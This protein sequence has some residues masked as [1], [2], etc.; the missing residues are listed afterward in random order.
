MNLI[1]PAAGSSTR[2][3]NLKPKWLLTHPNGNLMVAEAIRG[4]KIPGLK[5]IYLTILAEHVEKFKILDGIK[6]QFEQIGL[7]DKLTI[8]QLDKPTKSQPETVARAI[9]I[10][11]ITGPICIKDSDNYFELEVPAKN[12]VSVVDLNHVGF[13]NPGNKS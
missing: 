2:F 8:I 13:V 4:L 12:F 5:R 9:E 10:G 3:P 1:I 6:K 11:K 7:A